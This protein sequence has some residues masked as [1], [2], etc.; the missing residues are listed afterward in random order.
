L[1]APGVAALN[2]EVA[3]LDTRLSNQ[4]TALEGRV[5]A[6]ETLLDM[7]TSANVPN[8]L[9][10]RDNNGDIFASNFRGNLKEASAGVQAKILTATG[11][12]VFA[13]GENGGLPAF[14]FFG[15]GTLGTKQTASETSPNLAVDL[16]YDGETYGM[17]T[18]LP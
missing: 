7:A 9:V 15:P 13:A 18:R 16:L 17:L 4:I 14:Y 2:G 8:R 1:D 11:Q 6:L 3:D 12:E 5:A 10:M